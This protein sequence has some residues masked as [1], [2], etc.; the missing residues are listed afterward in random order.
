MP[1]VKKPEMNQPHGLKIDWSLSISTVLTVLVLVVSMAVQYGMMS[2]R[3]GAIEIMVARQSGANE[4]L[5]VAL[6]SLETTMVRLQTQMEERE[7]TKA[8]AANAARR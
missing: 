5:A 4:N 6:H 8:N 2:T 3:I 1:A 7:R